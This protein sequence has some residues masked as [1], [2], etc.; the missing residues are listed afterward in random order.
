[1]KLLS[2][3]SDPKTTKGKAYGYLTGIM[4]LAPHTLSGRNLCPDASPGCIAT[5]LNTAGMGGVFPTIQTGRIA[6]A[7]YFREDRAAFMRQL[8]REI[9]A[10]V[11]RAE[12]MGLTPLVR[13][14]GTSDIP[15]ENVYLDKGQL[16]QG[17]TIFQAFPDVQFY[18][19]T[20][21]AL[22]MRKY[23]SGKF[24]ANYALTFSRSECNEVEAIGV[25]QSG[26]NV[27]IPFSTHKGEALPT[28]WNGFV[29][30]DGDISDA[31]PSDTH[32]VVIGLRA[33]GKARKDTSGF[34]VRV[35]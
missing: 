15:W 29:V 13:L 7:V 32:G 35:N 31:R 33:K 3:D 2:I 14:N 26:G 28:R 25:L 17:G 6:R 16:G 21:S 11:R 34:V 24:P 23:L 5:C 12:R 30:T 4:Y 20:K 27:A 1:M 10:F 19:Y 8:V 18:D 22:R 9:A